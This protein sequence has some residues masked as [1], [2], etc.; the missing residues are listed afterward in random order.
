VFTGEGK[1]IAYADLT[2]DQVEQ[3]KGDP[4][5]V[6][7]EVELPAEEAAVEK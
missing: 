5:L 3:L 6:V 4:M 7:I 2:D 1:T